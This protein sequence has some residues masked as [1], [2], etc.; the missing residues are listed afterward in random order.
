MPPTSFSA[1]R[2]DP[3]IKGKW[4][5]KTVEKQDA[6]KSPHGGLQGHPGPPTVSIVA[7]PV[8]FWPP[9]W[10]PRDT[11]KRVF[12][13]LGDILIFPTLLCQNHVF[14]VPTAPLLSHFRSIFPRYLPDP[15]PDVLFLA[16]GRAKSR[17]GGARCQNRAPKDPPGRPKMVPKSILLAPVATGDF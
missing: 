4:Y 8:S 5:R 7:L 3:K 15:L 17:L 10:D 6:Q 1:P 16:R 2:P 12:L 13:Q 9:F 14:T 11:L